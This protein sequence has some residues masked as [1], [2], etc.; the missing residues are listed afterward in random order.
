MN[1][2][3]RRKWAKK[4]RQWRSEERVSQAELSRRT[5]LSTK[6]ISDMENGKTT[7]NND[8]VVRYAEGLGKQLLPE[9]LRDFWPD[10]VRD[11]ADHVG[12][13]LME[14]PEGE[15]DEL[16]GKVLAYTVRLHRSLPA[17]PP[18]S[19]DDSPPNGLDF[20]PKV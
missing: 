13:W 10:N 7:P 12:M 1:D 5:G 14:R 9:D 16:G 15:R 4:L 2:E 20:Q 6:T 19:S 17:K 3:L 11:Y 18:P 8:T